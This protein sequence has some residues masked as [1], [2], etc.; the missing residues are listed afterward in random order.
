MDDDLLNVIS[1]AES[2]A[3]EPTVKKG[4]PI[5]EAYDENGNLI[6]LEEDRD[7]PSNKD[8]VLLPEQVSHNRKPYVSDKSISMTSKQL[9]G[10]DGE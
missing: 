9:F 2:E 7:H 8:K 4:V 6:Q 3:Q 5:A 10:E 1:K